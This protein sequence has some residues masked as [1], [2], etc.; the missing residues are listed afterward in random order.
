MQNEELTYYNRY[1]D[2]I[3]PA[4]KKALE[5][6]KGHI[7]DVAM[8]LKHGV[9]Y[10]PGT[11]YPWHYLIKDAVNEDFLPRVKELDLPLGAKYLY[12]LPSINTCSY[13]ESKANTPL[14]YA[15]MERDESGSTHGW[16]VYKQTAFPDEMSTFPIPKSW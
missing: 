12:E 16:D 1:K 15:W 11:N 8:R 3:I 6:M 5:R 7:H 14:Y 13:G 9:G 10:L 2:S 4:T